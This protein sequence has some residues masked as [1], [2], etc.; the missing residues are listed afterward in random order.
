MSR[1]ENAN[2]N[3]SFDNMIWTSVPKILFMVSHTLKLGIYDALAIFNVGN[4]GRLEEL[5][6]K[7]T[8]PKELGKEQ[9]DKARYTSLI[10]V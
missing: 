5:R 4:A 1:W 3:E 6:V 2:V 8:I 7:K 10:I 9:V